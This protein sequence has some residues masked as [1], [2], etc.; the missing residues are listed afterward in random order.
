[1]L[2]VQIFK[3]RLSCVFSILLHEIVNILLHTK[4]IELALFELKTETLLLLSHGKVFQ[5]VFPRK[6]Y[7]FPSNLYQGI[8]RT[9][10]A[11]NGKAVITNQE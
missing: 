10:Q 7:H 8:L 2:L 5:G 3:N 9:N 11:R 1:M 4:Q 6:L